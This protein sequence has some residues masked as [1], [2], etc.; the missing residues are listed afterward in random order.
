MRIILPRYLNC[1]PIRIILKNTVNNLKLLNIEPS[2]TLEVLNNERPE[3]CMIPIA[4]LSNNVLKHYDISEICIASRGPVKS[5]GIYYIHDVDIEDIE[6]IYSTK[7][8]AT[9]IKILKHIFRIRFKK[10]IKIKR[11]DINR[12]NLDNI[13]N[14]EPVF[15]I[16]DL[17]LEA[18]YRHR[19]ILD[20][21]EEWHNLYNVPL[22]YAVLIYRR[23]LEKA[24]ALTF[25]IKHILQHTDK[26]KIIR[27][28]DHYLVKI[29]PYD[30]IEEYLTRDITYIIERDT[31]Y[32]ILDFEKKILEIV[33]I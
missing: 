33:N 2:K 11:I 31:L 23:D 30:L 26:N 27:E 7:E 32:K 22:I 9:S 28:I 12:E 18:Y 8:S 16:G 6:Q 24:K 13:I 21:G 20:I 15:L 4:Q 5:V 25:L 1:E 29:L 3:I 19:I 10:N 17:A 14:S